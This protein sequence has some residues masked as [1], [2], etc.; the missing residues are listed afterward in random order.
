MQM[1]IDASGTIHCLYGEE[2][3]LSGL[4]EIT[5]RRASFVEPVGNT[6]TADMSPVQGPILGP[7]P[8]RSQALQAE[9]KW[10]EQHLAAL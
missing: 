5:I 2:I 6:W 8:R 9:V 10:L 1:V 4:G 3:D 7:F